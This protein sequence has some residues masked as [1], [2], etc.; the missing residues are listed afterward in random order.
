M[1]AYLLDTHVFLWFAAGDVN[2]SKT[3]KN[4]IEDDK[5]D[6]YLSSASVWEL[7]IKIGIGKLKLKKSLGKFIAESIIQYGFIQLPI[8]IP[9]TLEI[10]KLPDIHKDPFDRVLIAQAIVESVKIIT[11]DKFINQYDVK[12]VW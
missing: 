7:S 2:L 6:I 5:N 11:S 10:S 8:N 4:I 1:T 9:H 3:A 12:T